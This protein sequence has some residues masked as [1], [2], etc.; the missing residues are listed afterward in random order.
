MFTRIQ[1]LSGLLCFG[2]IASAIAFVLFK[3][4]SESASNHVFGPNVFEPEVFEPDVFEPETLMPTTDRAIVTDP[5]TN[6]ITL[7][8]LDRYPDSE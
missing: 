7:E 2:L 6:A 1:L 5:A 8:A 3:R 4:Q